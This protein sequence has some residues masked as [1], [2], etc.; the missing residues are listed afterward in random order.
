MGETTVLGMFVPPPIKMRKREAQKERRGEKTR[1]NKTLRWRHETGFFFS[2]ETSS[3]FCVAPF[4]D[5][6]RGLS[7]LFLVNG[8]EE[9]KEKKGV[10]HTTAQAT[11]A[12]K[13]K[14][15]SRLCAGFLATQVQQKCSP[16]NKCPLVEIVVETNTGI[17]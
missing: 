11:F 14:I 8:R 3:S 17:Q 12:R 2:S 10:S 5:H 4:R 15:L 9:G 16:E 7:L 1:R 13:S 6:S